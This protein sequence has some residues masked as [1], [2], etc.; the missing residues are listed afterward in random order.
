MPYACVP[1]F[2]CTDNDSGDDDNGVD[3][4]GDNDNGVALAHSK[5][6]SK[7]LINDLDV[8]WPS[9]ILACCEL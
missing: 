1:L 7:G 9:K 8:S 6:C 3:D 4:V 5:I 2:A